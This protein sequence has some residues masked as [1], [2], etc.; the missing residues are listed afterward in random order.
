MSMKSVSTAPRVA[1]RDALDVAADNV[2][3]AAIDVRR[4]R[5]SCKAD[6]SVVSDGPVALKLLGC[7]RT[8]TGG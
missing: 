5:V 1:K 3:S 6:V 4:A 2:A 8:V 7:G